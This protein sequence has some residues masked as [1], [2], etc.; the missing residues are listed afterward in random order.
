VVDPFE[1]P[2][3]K[4]TLLATSAMKLL[5]FFVSS[6]ADGVPTTDSLIKECRALADTD[7]RRVFKSLLESS[8]PRSMRVAAASE[9]LSAMTGPGIVQFLIE[10]LGHVMVY[11]RSYLA[12]SIALL[13]LLK[14]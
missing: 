1:D 7:I 9:G 13:F 3:K 11:N 14:L 2:V 5:I 12:Y 10:I 4:S 6:L 8:Q